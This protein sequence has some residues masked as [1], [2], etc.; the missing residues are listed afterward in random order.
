MSTGLPAI[1]EMNA[2]CILYKT[3]E[4]LYI[5]VFVEVLEHITSGK[6]M[7]TVYIARLKLR[8]L[9]MLTPCPEHCCKSSMCAG[10][11]TS[12]TE[13][14]PSFSVTDEEVGACLYSSG[15]TNLI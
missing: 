8:M 6:H 3:L 9:I 7:M 5:L 13:A 10:P 4:C 11:K 2:P 1:D 14:E 15:A 12:M